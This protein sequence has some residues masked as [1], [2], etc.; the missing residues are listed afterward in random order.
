MIDTTEILLY[1]FRDNLGIKQ[2]CK[3][4]G[5][6][7]NT[8]RKYIRNFEAYKKKLQSTKSMPPCHSQMI[9]GYVL[10]LRKKSVISLPRVLTQELKTSI[11]TC[12]QEN[13]IKRRSRMKKQIM[14]KEDIHQLLIQQGYD[15]SY[16]SV[17]KYITRTYGSNFI[18]TFI[19]QNYHL[20][21]IA[22]FDWG[23][24]K[25]DINGVRR[26]FR[27]GAFAMA[28]ST[29]RWAQLFQHENTLSFQEAHVNFFNYMKGVP[30]EV[31]YDNMKVAVKR[32]VGDKQPTKGLLNL[33]THYHFTHRFCNIRRGNEKGHVERSVE[34][35]RRKAFSLNHKFKSLEEANKHLQHC[36]EKLNCLEANIE[37]FRKEKEALLSFDYEYQHSTLSMAKVNKLSTICFEHVHYSVPDFLTGKVVKLRIFSDKIFVYFNNKEVCMQERKYKAGWSMDLDHYLKTLSI[38]PG[39]LKGSMAFK[40]AP[41]RL[42]QIYQHHFNNDTKGF[43]ELLQYLK[44]INLGYK[45][46]FKVI[47]ELKVQNINK[48]NSQLIRSYIDNKNHTKSLSSTYQDTTNDPI[49]DFTN[50]NI[51]SLSNIYELC[52]Q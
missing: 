50:L 51:N 23:E 1:K 17:C 38:K 49:E 12:I 31:V 39:A 8:I 35:L 20:G 6:S 28:G 52:A 10:N 27:M 7:K 26:T 48:I 5:F 41:E 24:V 44:T 46:L 29:T 2:I 9:E 22:E 36:F 40:Q 43:I 13:E 21:Y 14:L 30:L 45:D 11:D 32:V 37:A 19:K 16:S 33:M 34:F 25:L 47:D 15:V 42:K 18:E 4:T 3:Q